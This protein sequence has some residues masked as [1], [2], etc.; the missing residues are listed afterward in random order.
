MAPVLMTANS[1]R[2]DK[3]MEY[4]ENKSFSARHPLVPYSTYFRA[5]RIQKCMLPV[6]MGVRQRR[7][8]SAKQTTLD[9]YLN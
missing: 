8:K 5:C 6:L 3:Y 7:E 1:C 2:H 4:F 9:N